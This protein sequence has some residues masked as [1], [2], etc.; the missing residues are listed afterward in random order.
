MQINSEKVNHKRFPSENSFDPWVEIISGAIQN[1]VRE[2][3]RFANNAQILFVVKNNAC[4]LGLQEIGPIV[5]TM[6]EI[7][8]FAVVRVDEALALRKV[9]VRKPILLMAHVCQSEAEELIHQDVM[10]T[11]FHD[12]AKKQVES[13]AKKLN[14]PIP[15][16]LYVETGMNRIGMPYERAVPWIEEIAASNLIKIAGTYTMT[17]GA[18]RGDDAFD[19]VQLVRFLNVIENA[20]RKGIDMG[21]LHAAPSRMIV[22]T[23]ASHQ[24]GIVRP[25]HAI[26]GGAI[27]N[28]DQDGN[29]IMNLE[30]T[31]QLKA[32]V[33][34][35]EIVREGE[36]VSFGH[37][38]IAAKPTWIA[39]IPIG[40]TDGYPSSA[41]N[42]AS[43]LIGRQVYPII[44][45]G[46]NSNFILVEVGD[47]QTVEVG[48]IATVIGTGHPAVAP[49]AVAEKAGLDSDY[50][51]MTKLNPLLHRRVV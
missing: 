44:A 28:F 36:G 45:G 7:Y 27:Y 14:R 24:L 13:L 16:Q 50:W 41:A 6:A 29:R 23:P 10:L 19:D 5:D 47:R 38:Y 12:N 3:H 33:V 15:V 2:V 9:G 21:V 1:N 22:K 48:D 51:I 26:F 43:V 25:G 40:H 11:L 37:R 35:V 34:R 30:L 32:R 49:Q 4:G 17:A 18:M 8:G 31:F 42:H 39:T 20:K 46:V